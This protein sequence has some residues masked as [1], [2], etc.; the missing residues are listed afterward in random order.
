M[1]E[2]HVVFFTFCPCVLLCVTIRRQQH[3]SV[4]NGQVLQFPHAATKMRIQ[5][6]PEGARRRLD[7]NA[8]G[9]FKSVEVIR[10][11]AGYGFTISGQRPCMLSGILEGSPA[12]LVGLRQGDCIMVINGSDV[13]TA[14]HEAVV[15]LIGSCKGPLCL[16]VQA[17]GRVLG[18][19]ILND[20][21]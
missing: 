6:Q 8:S 4:G 7:M 13:S 2:K 9:E 11:R 18:N 21:K 20:V 19:P 14:S 12:Y 16:V 5:G 17:E 15:Q 3:N 1:V 10:G